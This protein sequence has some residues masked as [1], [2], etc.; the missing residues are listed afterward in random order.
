[1][2]KLE[3]Q[4]KQKEAT[5]A[6]IRNVG[7]KLFA[8][9]G[10]SATNIVDISESAGISP[11]LI[12]H[13]YKSKEDLYFELLGTAINEANSVVRDIAAM[14]ISPGEK[15]TLLA[16]KI[17]KQAKED[18]NSAYFFVFVPQ[19]LLDKSI[20]KEMETLLKEAFVAIDILTDIV[21]EG[22]K[23]ME[24]KE[25]NT[26]ALATL[27][28]SSITG[29]CTYKIIL[30]ERFIFP[31]VKMLTS[32]LLR[33][34]SRSKTKKIAV[35]GG[36]ISG[37][38]AGI[39]A[40]L[41]G[42]EVEI[43]ESH[44][45]VGGECTSWHRKGYNIDGCIHWL[46]GSKP[47]TAVR[48]LWETCGALSSAIGVVNH[49]HVISCQDEEGQI[50]HLYSDLHKMI[51][52][53]L[54]I[55]PV[56][57][58]EI[59]RLARIVNAFRRLQMPV[60]PEEI[61]SLRAKI[62]MILPVLFI[63]KY[64]KFSMNI[65]TADYIKRFKSPII[66]NLLSG[67]VPNVLV[68][69]A[70]FFTLAARTDGDGGFPL[71]GSLHFAQ[72]M[73]QRFESLGGKIFL[74]SKVEK[75]IIKNN[76]AVGIQISEEINPRIFDYIVPA[77]D[78]H[79]LLYR[80]LEGKYSVP[81][82]ERRFAD[83]VK[84]PVVSATLV[85]IGVKTSLAHRPHSLI[86]KPKQP[87][88]VNGAEHPFLMLNHYACDPSLAP[89]GHT[90]VEF[91]L[92]DFSYDK[93]NAMRKQS[94]DDYQAE[95][96]RIGELML[97]ELEQNYPETANKTNL[98]DVTTPLTY[99]RYCNAYKG[100]YMSFLSTA[101]TT[102]KNHKGVIDGIDNLYIAGQWVF[103]DGG[104]PVAMLAGKFAIQRIIRHEK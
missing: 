6:K 38:S 13:Y 82:F 19:V 33:E 30:G 36:G 102:P 77:V 31:Q 99:S 97:A 4:N 22:Q 72:R 84:Y 10:L 85:A 14:L 7:L 43:Y 103:P 66:R 35:I 49:E 42:F 76:K 40:R 65:S 68:A 91:M 80:L 83:S 73:Q 37:L 58:K 41:Q 62:R 92:C 3:E 94:E 16:S 28:F 90:L 75:I 101:G 64:L 71:G 104:L 39:H 46:I 86:V 69:N 34:N 11:S 54:R 15:I 32:I 81:Y 98:L 59:K 2:S 1:M 60:E 53:L 96:Q 100:A 24:I 25:G 63:W 50:Y 44:N 52:E 89:K 70:L 21:A 57:K 18:E 20:P 55:S 61:M 87:V 9:K 78:A 23:S 56:D 27:F 8:T 51:N 17:L 45:N 79:T 74:E 95:K 29:L 47:G 26:R 67:V 88:I 5:I 12:Y 48:N 93:W